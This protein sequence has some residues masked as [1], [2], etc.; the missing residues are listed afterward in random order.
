MTKNA[1]R[2][3]R[4]WCGPKKHSGWKA[5]VEAV[6][7]IAFEKKLAF[8]DERSGGLGPLTW[9]EIGERRSSKG[10]TIR[11]DAIGLPRRTI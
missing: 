4:L 9:I 3:Y 5:D 1:A 10:K 8:R 11:V 2:F 7:Q 6:W